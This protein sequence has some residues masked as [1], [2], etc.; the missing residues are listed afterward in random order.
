MSE[1][2]TYL[3]VLMSRYLTTLLALPLLFITHSAYASVYQLE[4]KQTQTNTYLSREGYIITTR[5]CSA[6]PT[7]FEDV[8]LLYPEEN[9]MPKHT[10]IFTQSKT[11]HI[12]NVKSIQK[13]ES[14]PRILDN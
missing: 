6:E 14:F 13:G 8:V 11:T 3:E 9:H 1:M 12:C 4:I 10:L 7:Q 5:N 2:Y